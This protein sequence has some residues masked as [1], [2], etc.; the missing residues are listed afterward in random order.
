MQ[1]PLTL[2]ELYV[3]DVNRRVAHL[4][5]TTFVDIGHDLLLADGETDFTKMAGDSL[6]LAP[7]GYEIWGR[8]LRRFVSGG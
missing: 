2:S 4:P 7:G 6:H 5:G 3:A 1:H 8:E